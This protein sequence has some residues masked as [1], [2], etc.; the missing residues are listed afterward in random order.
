R[1]PKPET[2]HPKP[3]TRN[4]KPET[5]NP[6]PETRNPKPETRNPKPETRNPRPQCETP[7]LV[8]TTRRAQRVGSLSRGW[9]LV[10]GSPLRNQDLVNPQRC[11]SPYVKPRGWRPRSGRGRRFSAPSGC[12]PRAAHEHCTLIHAPYHLNLKTLIANR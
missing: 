2:R 12:P 1:N 11:G 10:E 8:A 3:E 5:R 9:C 7:S 6:K 4:L